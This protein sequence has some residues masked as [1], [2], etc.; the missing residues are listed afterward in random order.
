MSHH[1]TPENPEEKAPFQ[2][3][4]ADSAGNT[5]FDPDLLMVVERWPALPQA[6]RLG[7]VAAVKAAAG[8]DIGEGA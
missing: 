6:V 2:T 1:V 8:D 5:P 4:A 3:G 7:I